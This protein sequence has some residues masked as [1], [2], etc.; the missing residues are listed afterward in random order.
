MERQASGTGDS[1]VV[2][3]SIG[4]VLRDETAFAG[5]HDIE[6]RDGL[7]YVAGKG[8]TERAKPG[9][10]VYPYEKG[11]GGS[12]AVVDIE[13]PHAPKILW[14]AHETLTYEDAETVIPLGD[15]R[16]LVGTRELLLFDIAQPAQLEPIAVL[17][18]HPQVDA[19]NGF[20]RLGDVVFGS[21]KRGHIFAVDVSSPDSLG[22]MGARDTDEQ[23][24]LQMPHDV[25]LCKDLLVVVSPE[26]F[27]RD[28]KPGRIGTYR[29]TNPATG[30]VLPAQE[31]TMVGRIEDRRLSGANRVMVRGNFAYVGSSTGRNSDRN[32]SVSIVD[33]SDPAKP[34]LAGS[35]DFP[36]P[37]TEG[38]NGLEIAGTTVFAAGGQTVQAIDVSNPDAPRERSRLT[39]PDAFPGARDDAHDLVYHDGHLF[40]TAQNSHAL[41]V[42]TVSPDLARSI[43]P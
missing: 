31:W 29:V 13:Q 3:L 14:S 33:L 43:K 41:V 26:G 6:I 20:V 5:A 19:V 11:K 35:I 34:R 17:S 10:G 37:S 38:P 21:N 39:A 2:A 42:I 18:D 40:V 23:D 25:G 15:D 27:A 22:A 7:A 32:G 16:L 12:L 4:A 30:E 1:A 24:G 8:Y 28:N 9:N 36:D